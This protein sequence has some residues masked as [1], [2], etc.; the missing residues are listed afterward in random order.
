[1]KNVFKYCDKVQFKGAIENGP[2]SGVAEIIS[3]LN[4]SES[5][6]FYLCRYSENKEIWIRESKLELVSNE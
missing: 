6:T 2:Y 3:I 5:E 4:G 1:M